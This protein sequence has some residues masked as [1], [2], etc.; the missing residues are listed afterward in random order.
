GSKTSNFGFGLEI[1]RV[2]ILP[3]ILG[4]PG[5]RHTVESGLWKHLQTSRG[6]GV[7]SGNNLKY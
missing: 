4:A 5:V 6:A 1:G 7:L 2:Q 3:E